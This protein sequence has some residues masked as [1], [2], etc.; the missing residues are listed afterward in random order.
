VILAV[1]VSTVRLV[2]VMGAIADFGVL[3][4]AAGSARRSD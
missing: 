4:V 3:T 1:V 2:V